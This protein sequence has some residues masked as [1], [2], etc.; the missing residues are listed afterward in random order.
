MTRNLEKRGYEVRLFGER[1]VTRGYLAASDTERAAAFNA[2]VSDPAVKAIICARGGYGSP[3]ILDRID[4]AALARSP[5]V[6]IGYS[7]ITAL[8]IAVEQRCGL[9]T[10]HGPMG[11]EWSAARGISPYSELYYWDLFSGDSLEP[12]KLA[13]WGGELPSGLRRPVTLA[14]GVAEGVLVGGNLSVVTC[15]IG[16]PYAIE[17]EGAIL[18]LEEV[19]ERPF[20]IDRMLNQLRLAG[21][22]QGVKGVLLGVFA[23]CQTRDPE[24]DLSLEEVFGDYLTPLGV[25]VLYEY[26]AGHVPDQA[27]LPIG[28]RVRLDAT[29]RT[30]S[31]LEPCV[32]PPAQSESEG[33]PR[34]DGGI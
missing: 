22:L 18:F 24:G 9:V 20:H 30:L 13:D 1:D 3:R 23:A 28:S 8:L 33:V 4:Y 2:A 26:P 31:I 6:L 17:T 19:G 14:P 11:K 25:P 29:E 34:P 12:A 7:D 16:T 5:K 32:A 27:T 21:K 15:A 10:F